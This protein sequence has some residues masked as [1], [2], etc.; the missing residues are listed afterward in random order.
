MTDIIATI[1]WHCGEK[2]CPVGWH[3][4]NYW[5]YT[6][7]PNAGE[8]SED[9]YGDGD[10]EFID[11]KDVPTPEE[12]EKAESAYKAYV[13]ETGEDPLGYFTRY[14]TKERVENYTFDLSRSIVGI[15]VR[16]WRRGKGEWNDHN[17]DPP[18]HVMDFV[19]LTRTPGQA[20]LVVQD[21]LA[22]DPEMSQTEWIAMAKADEHVTWGDR[23]YMHVR[24][25]RQERQ[26]YLTISQG[27]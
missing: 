4:A 9:S 7:G 23:G 25:V 12:I 21:T 19:G 2:D 22:P 10:H 14:N 26:P 13:E 11:E 17:V 20:Y 3:E 16:R 5:Y 1:P 8:Y 24:L 18:Q 15:R 6:D 27:G